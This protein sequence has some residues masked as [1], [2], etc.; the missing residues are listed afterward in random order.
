[1]NR[2][3]KTI[4]MS[5]ICLFAMSAWAEDVNR[6]ANDFTLPSNTGSNIRLS[7]LK[8]QVVLVNFWASWC[9]PCKQEMPLLDEIHRQYEGLGFTVLGVNVEKDKR[10]ADRTL[11]QIPVSFPV[12]YDSENKVSQMYEV[13]AMPSS[14]IVGRDGNVRYIHEGYKPGDEAIYADKVRALLRE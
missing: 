9:G 1:M 5:L 6:P 13:N 8:G 11:K 4:A 7:E 2:M 14:V 12:L 3:I 10:A